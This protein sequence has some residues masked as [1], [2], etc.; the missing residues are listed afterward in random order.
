MLL[1]ANGASQAALFRI[2]SRNS[3]THTRRNAFSQRRVR[4]NRVVILISHFVKRRHVEASALPGECQEDFFARFFFKNDVDQF[5]SQD[6]AFT[7][8]DHVREFSNGFRIQERRSAPHDDQR[9]ARGTVL[10]PDGYTAHLQHARHVYVV[11]FKR[12]RQG[13]DIKI[14]HRSLRLK[15]KQR[16]ARALVLAHLVNVIV[17]AAASLIVTRAAARAS[18][19]VRQKHSLT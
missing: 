5:W 17:S 14:A 18:A 1:A 10:G 19:A 9:I 8:A 13:D 4:G 12:D 2:L 3:P 16:R 15:R 11:S 6:F 7:H